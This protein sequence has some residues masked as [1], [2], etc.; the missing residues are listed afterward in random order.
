MIRRMPYYTFELVLTGMLRGKRNPS[1]TSGH[2]DMSWGQDPF[3]A[4]MSDSESPL[5]GRFVLCCV[6]YVG[7]KPD[8][9]IEGIC[10][11]LKPVAEF[12]GDS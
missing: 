6:E 11:A 5:T 2:D 4:I 1:Q 8:S 9:E 3:S 12:L 7:R 10:V